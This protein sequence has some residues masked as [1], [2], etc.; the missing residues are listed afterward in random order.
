MKLSIFGAGVVL[1]MALSGA[2]VAAEATDADATSGASDSTVMT[3]TQDTKATRKQNTETTKGGRPQ[4]S[5]TQKQ[6][7]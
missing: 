3:Q 6:S 4:S 7:D 5:T 1:G 2:V